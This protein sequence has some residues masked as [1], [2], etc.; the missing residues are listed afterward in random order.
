MR[1]HLPPPKQNEQKVKTRM[2]WDPKAL[3]AV[4]EIPSFVQSMVIEMTED[5]V[6]KE[7]KERMTYDRFMELMKE[8]AP[9]EVLERFED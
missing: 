6:K 1:E 3:Q 7:G 5:I 2:P 9:D 8:Y 4:N